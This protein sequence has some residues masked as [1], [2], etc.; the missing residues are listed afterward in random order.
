[1]IHEREHTEKGQI[2][3]RHHE[4]SEDCNIHPRPPW[5]IGEEEISE[6]LSFSMQGVFGVHHE[7]A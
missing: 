4:V 1:M 2:Y 3:F 6:C 5:V 7:D